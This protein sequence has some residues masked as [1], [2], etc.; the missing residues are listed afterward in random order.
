MRPFRSN[1]VMYGVECVIGF[2]MDVWCVLSNLMDH[3]KS[4]CGYARLVG[5][6]IHKTEVIEVF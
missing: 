2:K 5:L 6:V 1:W 4:I 3:E